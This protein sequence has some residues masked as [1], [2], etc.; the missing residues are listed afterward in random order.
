MERRRAKRFSRRLKVNF[1]DLTSGEQYIGYSTNISEAGLFLASSHL[2][3]V[4]SR[5]RLEVASADRMIVLEGAVARLIRVPAQLRSMQNVGMGIRFMQVAELVTEVLPLDLKATVANATAAPPVSA[6]PKPGPAPV[7]Q[8]FGPAAVHSPSP[9]AKVP[10]PNPPGQPIRPPDTLYRIRIASEAELRARY[11]RELRYGGL[12]V[13][14]AQPPEVDSIIT[15]E[16]D[17]PFPGRPPFRVPAR[18]VHRVVPSAS[19][20]TTIPGFA[21]EFQDRLGVLTAL[22]PLVKD[23][24]QS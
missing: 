7:A 18:V 4:G 9:E 23:P 6:E 2:L 1:V 13:P 17:L 15:V 20:R 5:I 3:K 19:D 14:S 12:F 21:V 8:S 22:A 16:L 10:P 24:Q 11:A